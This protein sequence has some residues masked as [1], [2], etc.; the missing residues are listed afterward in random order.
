MRA[1]VFLCAI[2]LCC[3]TVARAQTAAAPAA[4]PVD[5]SPSFKVGG[6]IFADYTFQSSPK[7]LD[8]DGNSV[9]ASSFNVSRAYI[10]VTGKLNHWILFRITPEAARETG[11]GSSLNGSQTFRLKFGYA[12]FNLDDWAPK[13]TWVRFGIQQTPLIDYE[14]TIHRYR[15]QGQTF[16]DREGYVG[17]SDAGISA[18]YDFPGNH[19][20]LHGGIYN[21]DGFNKAEANDQ[22]SL[23]LRVSYRPLPGSPLLKGLRITGY[24]NSDHVV[25]GAKRERLLEQVTYENPHVNAGFDHISTTDAASSHARE[26]EG[27][28]YSLWVTPRLTPQWELLFRHDDLKPDDATSQH[29]TRNIAGVAY[30]V[31][32]LQK[33]TAAFLADYDSLEQKNYSPAR[34]KDTRYGLKMLLQF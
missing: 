4:P 7:T 10:N 12:Q 3:A 22:K 26:I 24:I 16:T 29:R 23:Q 9:H 33:V 2:A 21:G 28:G 25:Q 6:V 17:P 30:W 15:F 1:S 11:S 27:D 13:G 34:P 20:D 8:S 5:D 18:H 32:N 19:G 14:E 31:P